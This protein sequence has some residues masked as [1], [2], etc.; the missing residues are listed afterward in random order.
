MTSKKTLWTNQLIHEKSPYLQ[1]HAHNPVNWYPWGNEAVEKARQEDKPIF[2]SIGY[3]TCHWCHVMEKESFENSEMA[4]LLN[5]DFVS[6]K[7]DREE[8]P[9]VDH[10]YMTAVQAMTGQGGWPMSVFLTPDLKPFFG[11]TYFPPEDRWGRPGF[12][13]VL[14]AIASQ[15]KSDREKLLKSSEALTASL[16]HRSVKD[17]LRQALDE[18]VLNEG[19]T[20]LIGQYDE[21]YGGFGEAPKFPRSHALS[22]LLR[23]WK[24]NGDERLLQIVEKTLTEMARGGMRDHLG[25]GFHRYSVDH[26]WRIPHFEK[27]LYDQAILSKTYLEAYQATGKVEYANVAKDIFDDVLRDMTPPPLV[28]LSSQSAGGGPTFVSTR[29]GGVTGSDGAFYSA[30]DADSAQN[31]DH[32]DEKF[33]GVFYLWEDKVINELLGEE[34]AKILNLHFGVLPDGNALHDPQGEFA[35]KN[36]LYEALSLSQISEKLGLPL[37]E[38]EK[39]ISNSKAKLFEERKKRS[40]PHLDDKI[41]T[42]WNGLMISSLAIASRV[43]GE[44]RYLVAA[45]SAADFILGRMK[46]KE[47]RLMHRF[48]KGDVSVL[49]FLEDYAFLILGL[50]D[51]YEASFNLYYFEEA[52]FL[53]QEMIR[54]FWDDEEGG[55][56]FSGKDAEKLIAHSKEIYDGAIPSGNSVAALVLLRLA[57]LKAD[58]ALEKRAKSLLDAFSKAM[59]QYPSGYTQ[60]LIALEFT[61]SPTQEIIF[62]GDSLS[63]KGREILREIF[64]HFLPHHVLAFSP[65][66][67]RTFEK[68]S[69]LIPLIQGRIFEGEKPTV[70]ICQNSVCNSPVTEISQLKEILSNP[71]LKRM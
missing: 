26:A 36:V 52:W 57:R 54:L 19:F 59:T 7:V 40:R 42:D 1:Q 13:S 8:R 55:F 32:P 56:Y 49:G 50:L 17:D 33:E 41:L 9:D 10:V 4:H 64:S 63:L 6:I 30:E 3:S 15:W 34:N 24:R 28:G 68:A 62:R 66:D 18:G 44:E 70:Y 27:M 71:I 23:G 25:G 65:V 38:I 58:E 46:S 45:S 14:F 53:S 2:L 31:A 48:C 47:G 20:Q 61:L 39:S 67:S 5:N 60:M 16:Q 37:E 43:F 22:F 11:G 69:S 35:G 21:A 12:A 51:L 29:G